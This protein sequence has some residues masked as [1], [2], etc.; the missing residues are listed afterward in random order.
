MSLANMLTPMRTKR[1]RELTPEEKAR[2]AR[3]RAI[4]D[5]YRQE[6]PGVS[7][8]SMA[9]DMGWKTQG[10][11]SQYLNGTIPLN[12]HAGLRFAKRL[13]VPV[14]DI[15]PAWADD[16]SGPHHSHTRTEPSSAAPVSTSI[17]GAQ[18]LQSSPAAQQLVDQLLR[19]ASSG[20]LP[21]AACA[22][23]TDLL[24]AL[25]T[26]RGSGHQGKRRTALPD[27]NPSHR[28]VR[29]NLKN[30]DQASNP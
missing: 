16:L 12:L 21:D 15:E 24:D 22:A 13:G 11:V 9:F 30:N 17:G 5:R 26:E 25:L 20:Q 23:L 2:A 28:R 3:L 18:Y 27:D 29:E 6:N 14:T 8:E 19:L 4:W 7:Q 1:R 10:A